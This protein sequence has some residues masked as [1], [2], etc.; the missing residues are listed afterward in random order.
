MDKL[1]EEQRQKIMGIHKDR[2]KNI[3]EIFKHKT[4]NGVF[5]PISHIEMQN[6]FKKMEYD[7]TCSMNLVL[8]IPPPPPLE[9]HL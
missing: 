6:T 2:F 1:T 9:I 3:N 5:T 4:I 8:E 7:Y